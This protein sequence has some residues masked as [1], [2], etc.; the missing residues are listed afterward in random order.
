VGKAACF[1]SERDADVNERFN[2]DHL[3]SNSIQAIQ[4][5][6]LAA[7][8]SVSTQVRVEVVTTSVSLVE[9]SICNF[10]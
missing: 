8:V 3:S 2:N 9:R 10:V 4:L 5:L 7:A 1:N 6:Q